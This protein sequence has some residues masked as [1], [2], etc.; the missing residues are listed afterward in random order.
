MIMPAEK[1]YT[2]VLGSRWGPQ[3]RTAAHIRD[4]TER[5][6]ILSRPP[7]GDSC[8]TEGVEREQ[9]K[10]GGSKAVEVGAD[11]GTSALCGVILMA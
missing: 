7:H 1:A 5:G 9:G 2:Q 4:T 6:A 3:A 8:C 11:K 10:V